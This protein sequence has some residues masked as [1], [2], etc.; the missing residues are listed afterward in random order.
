M[1]RCAVVLQAEMHHIAVQRVPYEA[2]L[3]EPTS[4]TLQF[5]HMIRYVIRGAGALVDPTLTLYIAPNRPQ[6]DATIL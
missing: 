6:H 4:L 3:V 5:S 2:V 1:A